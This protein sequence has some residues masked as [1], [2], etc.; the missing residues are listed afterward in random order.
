M[1]LTSRIPFY[2]ILF[3][4]DPTHPILFYFIPPYPISY[5]V[6]HLSYPV[7]F[8]PY[9]SQLIR[10]P[11]ITCSSPHLSHLIQFFPTLSD[12]I[13][14]HVSHLWVFEDEQQLVADTQTAQTHIHINVHHLV[15]EI[16]DKGEGE[17]K[18]K[19]G[20]RGRGFS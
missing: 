17:G 10:S 7:L 20:D 11:I 5:R 8:C 1:F 9:P 3:Y 13:S 12:V 6:A 2:Y 14:H 4:P 18:G 19:E 16:P 15:V